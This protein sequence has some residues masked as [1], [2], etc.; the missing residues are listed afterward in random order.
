MLKTMNNFGYYAFLYKLFMVGAAVADTLSH[1]TA[2]LTCDCARK[3]SQLWTNAVPICVL[4]S[5][6]KVWHTD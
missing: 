1:N 5:V 6:R 2:C 4:N 3:T